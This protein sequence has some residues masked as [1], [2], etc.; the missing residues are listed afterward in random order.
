[1]LDQLVGRQRRALSTS[2]SPLRVV[3]KRV[4]I[5]PRTLAPGAAAAA[6]GKVRADGI[7]GA[8]R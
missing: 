5:V 3:E 8:H 2:L 4:V 6:L 7:D 1:M